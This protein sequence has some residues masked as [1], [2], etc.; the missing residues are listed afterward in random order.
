MRIIWKV[1]NGK[2]IEIAIIAS[3]AKRDG[4]LVYKLVPNRKDNFWKLWGKQ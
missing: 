2:T 4:M 3:I 1:S